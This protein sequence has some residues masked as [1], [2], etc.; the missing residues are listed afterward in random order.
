MSDVQKGR[1]RVGCVEA[2]LHTFGYRTM[3]SSRSGQRL[4]QRAQSLA[5]DGDLLAIAPQDSN[6][7][8]LIAEIGGPGKRIDSSIAEMVAEGLPAGVI[9]IVVKQ[10]ASR[11]ERRWRWSLSSDEGYDTLEELLDAVRER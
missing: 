2:I 6:L 3:I 9:P 7:P 5:I 4:A 8:H 1:K 10:T 11:P